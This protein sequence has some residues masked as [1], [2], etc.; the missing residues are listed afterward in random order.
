MQLIMQLKEKSHAIKRQG[1]WCCLQLMQL[2]G[3]GARVSQATPSSE[4][5]SCDSRSCVSLYSVRLAL[6]SDAGVSLSCACRCICERSSA[7]AQQRL[8]PCAQRL[9]YGKKLGPR[10]KSCKQ[11]LSGGSRWSGSDA[12]NSGILPHALSP[13]SS[14]CPGAAD[15]PAR[16]PSTPGSYPTR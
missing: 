8:S 4:Q 16:M 12:I 11:Y 14:T 5:C 9:A 13:V 15:S 2:T 7:A 6:R 1:G 10:A 3:G